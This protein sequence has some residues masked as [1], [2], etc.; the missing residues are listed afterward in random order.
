M[1]RGEM[2]GILD[3]KPGIE[4]T[5]GRLMTGLEITPQ[6]IEAGPQAG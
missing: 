3:N 1:Y 2:V 4:E 5:L 6:V